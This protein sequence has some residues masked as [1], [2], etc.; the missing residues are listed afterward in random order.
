MSDWKG[1]NLTIL[2]DW[3][4]GEFQAMDGT[5]ETL[6]SAEEI[7]TETYFLLAS[8]LLR[9]PGKRKKDSFAG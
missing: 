7:Q 1:E 5:Y 6:T 9:T 2:A 8:S 3:S 4:I